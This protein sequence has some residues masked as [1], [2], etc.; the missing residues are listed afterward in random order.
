[1]PYLDSAGKIAEEVKIDR[2]R[3]IA[4]G[5]RKLFSFYGILES[6]QRKFLKN[7][8]GYNWNDANKVG[9]KLNIN[10]NSYKYVSEGFEADDQNPKFQRLI[11]YRDMKVDGR[12]SYNILLLND[13]IGNQH[14]I[15]I[16]NVEKL[17]GLFICPICNNHAIFAKDENR[18]DQRKMDAHIKE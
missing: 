8:L 17:I 1:M 12:K 15:Y 4:E 3:R 14:I 6:N 13:N 2:H 18:H 11:S 7:Y 10:I 5:K 9:E 16:I